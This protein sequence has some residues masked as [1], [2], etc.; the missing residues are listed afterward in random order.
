MNTYRHYP[1]VARGS[2]LIEVLVSMLIL[3]IG[4]LAVASLQASTMRFAQGSGARAAIA[5]TLSDF[6]DRIRANPA[7]A[8]AAYALGTTYPAQRSTIGA[9]AATKECGNSGITCNEAELAAYDLV[10]F[11]LNLNRNMP[12]GAGFVTGNRAAGFVVTVMWADKTYLKEEANKTEQLDTSEVCTGTETGI[13]ARTCCP[14]A[15]AAPAGVRC[16]NMTVL[17]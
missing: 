16:T 7:S 1:Q 13:A 9:L 11:R 14:T 4:L 15:A 2:T 10:Q 3:S 12:G 8:T 5:S 17:P 6:A